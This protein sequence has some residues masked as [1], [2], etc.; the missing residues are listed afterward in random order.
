[1]SASSNTGFSGHVL[2]AFFATQPREQAFMIQEHEL[3][4]GRAPARHDL[5]GAPRSSFGGAAMKLMASQQTVGR[6]RICRRPVSGP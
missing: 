3:F 1:V 5:E 6:C 4:A 2:L